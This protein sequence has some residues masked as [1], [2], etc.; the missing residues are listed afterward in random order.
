MDHLTVT[1]KQRAGNGF[2]LPIEI[3]RLFLLVRMG[4]KEIEQVFGEQQAGSFGKTA[5]HVVMTH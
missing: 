2:V 4:R 1:T 5:R 3:E